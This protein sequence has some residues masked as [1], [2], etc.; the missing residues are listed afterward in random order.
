VLEQPLAAVVRA[1]VAEGPSSVVEA[2]V[3]G[4]RAWVLHLRVTPNRNGFSGDALSVI[5]DRDTGWPLRVHETLDGR[6]VRDLRV[7]ALRQAAT[8]PGGS[9]RARAPAGAAVLRLDGG[10]RSTRPAAA[11][12]RVGYA[13][14]LPTSLPAGYRRAATVTAATAQPTGNE[15]MNPPS[16]GV[17]STVYRRGL[18]R[19]VVTS[20]LRGGTASRW[21][22]PLASGEGYTDRSTAARL[23]Q[24]ALRGATAR[25]VT[26]ARGVPHLWALTDRLVVTVSGDLTRAELL[27]AAR[28]LRP[29]AS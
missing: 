28:S 25:V 1:I 9:L 29:V 14:P 3:G 15:A 17:V 18:E 27:T 12:E 6:L 8:L 19:V 24:G 23:R 20:R 5:V 22:D 16:R 26:D 11:R 4:R 21:T 10:F 7:V 2:Q 13:P